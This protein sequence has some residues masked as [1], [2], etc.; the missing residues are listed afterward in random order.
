M[1]VYKP[2]YTRPLPAGATKFT[3]RSGRHKG[4]RFAKFKD[5]RGNTRTERLT[6]DGK[7]I[8]VNTK[9]WRIQF[10]DYLG[11]KRE[12][13]A[14]SDHE[15]SNQ[16]ANFIQKLLNYKQSNNPL[17]SEMQERFE[18]LPSAIRNELIKFGA[19]DAQQAEIGKPL[20]QHVADYIDFLTKRERSRHY[21][22]EVEGTLT[23]L[24]KECK[25]TVWKDI[26]AVRLKEFL[27]EQR[28]G[29][30]GISKRRYNGLLGITKSFCRWM[31]RQQRASSSPIE[32]L[33]GMDDPQT[34]LRHPRRALS[35]N[36]FRRFL[37]AA[38]NS[39]ETIYGLKGYERNLL[40]R[41]AAETGL[42]SADIRRL[43]VKDFD[44]AEKKFIVRACNT[45]NKTDATVYLKPATAA[46]LK[47]YCKNKLPNAPVFYVTDKTAKMLR[48]DLANTAVRDATGKEIE[49]AIPYI[50][51]RGEVFDFHSLRHQTASMLAMNPE[52]P[53]AVRQQVMR[54]KTPEMTRHYSH[55]FEEQQRQAIESMPDLTQPSRESQLSAKTG[56]DNQNFP[57]KSCQNSYFGNGHQCNYRTNT[58]TKN[59]DNEKKTQFR[60]KNVDEIHS[61]DPKVEG[62]SPF[63]LA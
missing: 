7:K 59:I 34:D 56:T 40:Y 53:E 45:K 49:P 19:V 5:K 37:E 15:A 57:E 46:E 55:S 26:S 23:R 9:L 44:F 51:K 47:Q 17:T 41:F 12:L 20:T 52:T 2:A 58:N 39:S 43:R 4:T 62:S 8:L 30:K 48:H 29:G 18:H 16:L 3:A 42:R 1:R 61:V 32:F 22:K 11:V 21:I 60:S 36:E 27:D 10:T 50:N 25:F 63:G 13:K 24:F 38:L 31:V 54:H 14:Y 33:E 35:I 28:D 6:K